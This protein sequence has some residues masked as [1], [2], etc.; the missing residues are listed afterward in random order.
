ML[1]CW[2]CIKC[3]RC[4]FWTAR[5]SS[6]HWNLPVMKRPVPSWIS[7]SFDCVRYLM[8]QT[9]SSSFIQ[10]LSVRKDQLM[11]S[12]QNLTLTR[13]NSRQMEACGPQQSFDIVAQEISTHLLDSVVRQWLIFRTKEQGELWKVKVNWCLLLLV[14]SQSSLWGLRHNKK[15]KS[16]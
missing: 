12:L 2:Q 9:F 10:S 3:C 15:S 1:H 13:S 6:G 4:Y 11:K 5:I 14:Q 8:Y 16:F 7:L